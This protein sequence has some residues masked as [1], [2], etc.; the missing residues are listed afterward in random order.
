MANGLTEDGIYNAGGGLNVTVTSVPSSGVFTVGSG[1][2]I[3]T[4]QV[5]GPGTQM[6]DHSTGAIVGVVTGNPYWVGST[7][8]VPSGGPVTG[9]SNGSPLGTGYTD[10]D[11]VRIVQAGCEGAQVQLRVTAGVPTS[12]SVYTAGQGCSAGTNLAVT[13]GSGTNYHV[14]VTSTS[15]TP[16]NGEVIDL[17]PNPVNVSIIRPIA[18]DFNINI[19]IPPVF[20]SSTFGTIANLTFQYGG[21]T[22]VGFLP[23]CNS[24]SNGALNAVTNAASAYSLSVGTIF[25]QVQCQGTTATW[26]P[27]AGTG[28]SASITAASSK[29]V[30]SPSPITGTGTVD[31]GTVP[32][33]SLA[34]QAAATLIGNATSGSAAPT[35]ITLGT[36][37]SFTGSTLNAAGGGLPSS[38][39]QQ[40]FT[41][42]SSNTAVS[43]ATGASGALAIDTS[44]VLD[45]VTSVV[46]R[47]AAANTWTGAQDFTG[48]SFIKIKVGTTAPPCSVTGDEGSMWLDT[49][50]ATANHL[51]VC[52]EVSSTIGFQ[53]IF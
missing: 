37:L 43:T 38:S 23:P 28:G 18:K 41:T 50:T 20:S 52:A 5:A 44:G 25:S 12:V 46:P 53:T 21:A 9:V 17:N 15:G 14:N 22:T 2:Q 51:K 6:I 40:L 27:I 35:A 39:A 13:G 1:D 16:T 26:T 3:R 7:L 33:T 29:I 45:I 42:N 8:T 19:G 10:F 32:L 34:T 30:V 49:T 48:A 24:H 11:V 31:L 47:V 36:N 4:I